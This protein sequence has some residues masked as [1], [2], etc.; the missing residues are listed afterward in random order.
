M[1]LD[2]HAHS[3]FSFDGERPMEEMVAAAAARGLSELCFTDHLDFDSPVH[4]IP[5]YT[6]RRAEAERLRP[7]YPGLTISLGA[8][9]SLRDET[10]AARARE[11]LRVAEADFILGSVH[12]VDG[13]DVWSDRYYNGLDKKTAYRRYLEAVA[14]ELPTFPEFHV[15][16]HYD[17]VAKYAPYP[18][19]S[20]TLDS[21]P[22]A[23]DLIFRY[24][25]D[26]GKGLEINTASWQQDRPWG[27]DILRRYRELGGEFVTVGS[28]T[29]GSERVGARIGE[30]LNLARA[31][32]IPY[33]AAF[34]KGKPHFYALGK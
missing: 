34:R 8:E 18:D 4:H 14:Q 16:A 2:L 19:R 5:D 13:V 17:F 11:T 29:H 28:D 10:C 7:L 6:A 23:F 22:D 12:T 30:A 32:G 33:I 25:L 15:L 27:L 1:N 3:Q 9:V 31:A 26:S 21:A 24:L 20:V